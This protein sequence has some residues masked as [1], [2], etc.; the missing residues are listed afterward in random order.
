MS[1]TSRLGLPFIESGQAQKEL[2]HN[3]ALRLIDVAVATAVET[4]GGNTPPS[5]PAAGQC[6]IVGT[7]PTGVWAGHGA[8]IAGYAAGGWRF[9]AAVAG[10]RALDKSGGQTACFDGV[11][12]TVGTI[13]GARLELS[14]SQVVGPR[15]AAVV[16]PAG[17]TTVDVE[18]RAA[19]VAILGRMRNH[20]LIAP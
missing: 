6:F 12:W 3:E 20:G 5:S 11:A 9:V 13:K 10:M 4:V 17:G 7:T 8:A 19:L 14:G 18:A 1:Q 16:D 2:F 15:L